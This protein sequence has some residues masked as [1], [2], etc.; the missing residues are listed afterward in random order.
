MNATKSIILL[1]FLTLIQIIS[2]DWQCTNTI[3]FNQYNDKYH[4]LIADE[5]YEYSFNF[6]FNKNIS[7]EIGLS[8][9]YSD[10]L[11]DLLTDN[12]CPMNSV[13]DSEV[14]NTVGNY[15]LIETNNNT[16]YNMTLSSSCFERKFNN[17]S[18]FVCKSNFEKK[19]YYYQFIVVVVTV[20]D[21]NLNASVIINSNKTKMFREEQLNNVIRNKCYD[22]KIISTIVNVVCGLLV[23]FVT[24]FL[25]GSI[26]FY[27]EKKISADKKMLIN[28]VN[29]TS[30]TRIVEKRYGYGTR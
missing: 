29:D 4:I 16:S 22:K 6:E 17:T 12:D 25:I 18:T 2:T 27:Y 3:N 26:V 15:K 8:T 19:Y 11:C 21:Q 14:V 7:Y 9:Y 13:L 24:I 23:F 28:C 1:F 20:D 30:Y 5:A 10:K